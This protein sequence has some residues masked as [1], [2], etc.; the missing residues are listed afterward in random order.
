VS[1][2][3]GKPRGRWKKRGPHRTRGP[4]SFF[5][6]PAQPAL[7]GVDGAGAYGDM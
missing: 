2:Q 3:S 6:C 4:L 7:D 1:G 5:A